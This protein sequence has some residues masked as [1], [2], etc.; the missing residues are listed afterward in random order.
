MRLA[1]LTAAWVLLASS[2]VHAESAFQ[3]RLGTSPAIWE[4]V[5]NNNRYFSASAK[6]HRDLVQ[7]RRR[8]KKAWIG[9]FAAF[10]VVNVFDAHSSAGRREL[11]PLLRGSDGRISMSRAI[12]LK[13]AIGGGMMALQWAAAK[14]HKDKN[15]YKVFTVAN[16]AVSGGLAVVAAHNYS[17][18]K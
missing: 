7:K 17:L 6:P 16:S 10:A 14:K 9:S 18:A 2:S 15:Y 11:N 5:Q 12:S 3:A 13:A 1:L 8:W 4:A